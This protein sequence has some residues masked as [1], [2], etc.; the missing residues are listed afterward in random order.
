MWEVII[1]VV[2]MLIGQLL[3]KNSY[4]QEREQSLMSLDAE[5]KDGRSLVKIAK[6]VKPAYLVVIKLILVL[7][8]LMGILFVGIVLFLNNKQLYLI[9]FTVALVVFCIIQL[10]GLVKYNWE[11]TIFKT[12]RTKKMITEAISGRLLTIISAVFL[13]SNIILAYFY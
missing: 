3:A 9:L 13:L 6:K 1:S 4:H 11:L 12:V 2:L 5:P 10:L 8:L 7:Y